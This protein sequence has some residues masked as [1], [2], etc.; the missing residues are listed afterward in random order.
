[1]PKAR[2]VCLHHKRLTNGCNKNIVALAVKIHPLSSYSRHCYSSQ[3]FSN[4]IWRPDLPST[5]VATSPTHH[6]I[7]W[8]LAIL[9]TLGLVL[10]QHL[11]HSAFPLHE[12]LDSFTS[13]IRNLTL[14]C[15]E[16]S[17]VS[18]L[19]QLTNPMGWDPANS[20]PLLHTLL[21]PPTCLQSL[22]PLL[23]PR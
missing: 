12:T 6:E 20:L 23:F 2:C 21:M 11:W 22:D 19:T 3:P 8:T 1:M 17:G 5:S 18:C 7:I 15:L 10:S 9:K 16:A 14:S 4:Q 13:T